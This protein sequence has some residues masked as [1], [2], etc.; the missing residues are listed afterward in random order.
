MLIAASLFFYA[1]GQAQLVLL[2]LASIGINAVSSYAILRSGRGAA[3]QGWAI[4]GVV[5]NLGILIVFK[6]GRLLAGSFGV[7]LAESSFGHFLLN[8]PLPIGISFFTFQG[9]SLVVDVYRQKPDSP[10]RI[11][12]R[13]STRTWWIPRSLSHSSRNSSRGR[14]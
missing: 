7:S 1:Y 10:E 13:D 12:H 2:L 5:L 3:R 14:L 6:Y 11:E 4:A 9:I 8:A